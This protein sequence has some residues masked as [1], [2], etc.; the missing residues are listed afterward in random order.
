LFDWLACVEAALA[1]ADAEISIHFGG[2]EERT[3]AR[4]WR[5]QVLVDWQPDPHAGDCLLRI[6]LLRELVAL[7]ATV[8]T[9]GVGGSHSIVLDVPGRVAARLSARHA[10]LIARLGGARRV[11]L[12]VHLRFDAGVYVGGEETYS[13]RAAPLLR[14]IAQ[15]RVRSASTALPR[16]SPAPT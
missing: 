11:W 3:S 2:R 14:L 9:E 7:K 10:E 16:T 13:V 6:E 4:L 1:D 12:R 15:V 8:A 5:G